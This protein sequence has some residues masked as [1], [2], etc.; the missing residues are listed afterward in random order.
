MQKIYNAAIENMELYI[1]PYLTKL[2]FNSKNVDSNSL[3][4][5]TNSNIETRVGEHMVLLVLSKD[6]GAIQSE[7]IIANN[8]KS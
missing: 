6:N 4:L 3:I 2:S 1:C 8:G 7:T 5:V